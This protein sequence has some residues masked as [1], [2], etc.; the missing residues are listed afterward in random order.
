M[1]QRGLKIVIVVLLGLVCYQSYTPKKVHAQ[2]SPGIHTLQVTIGAATTQITTSDIPAR[3]VLVQN[4]S[5]HDIRLG[6]SNT[7]SSRGAVLKASSI[8][9]ANFGSYQF[10]Q[11]NLNQLYVNGTQNDVVDVLYVN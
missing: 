2:G 7:S 6:D 1:K 4:N 11:I 3:Q 8:G 9:S 10:E 5:T